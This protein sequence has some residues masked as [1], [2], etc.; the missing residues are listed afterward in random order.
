MAAATTAIMRRRVLLI[1]LSIWLLGMIFGAS[2]GIRGWNASLA[3][4]DFA[5]FWVAGKIARSG[6]AALVY[7]PNALRAAAASWIGT[8]AKIAFPY[9]PHSLL[10]AVPLSLVPYKLS[11]WLWQSVSAALFY[12]AA[13]P[14]LPK[15]FPAILAVLTPAALINVAL[16]QVGLFYGALWLFAFGGS[17]IASAMLT[18]KP[19]LGFLVAVEVIRKRRLV[20]TSIVAVALILLSLLV[21]GANAWTASLLQ[22]ASNQV[23]MLTSGAMS[24]WPTQMTTP[25]LTYGVAGWALFASAAAFLLSRNFNV[26]TAATATFLIAPYGFHYDMT[27]V[28]LGFG[29]LLFKKWEEMP[30]W[31]RLAC[32]LAFLTPGL[33]AVESWLIPPLLLLGLYVQAVGASGSES[34]LAYQPQS[35]PTTESAE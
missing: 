4:R 25:L 14:H 20:R 30:V 10:F 9:P 28:C 23:A 31:Q 29:V 32:T 7:D 19:H 3:N 13:K 6:L 27:V 34:P 5:C 33:V 21:F 15:H 26:F 16:G 12:V 24:K 8:T 1:V 2:V 17:S 35:S 18:F 11:F 22:G